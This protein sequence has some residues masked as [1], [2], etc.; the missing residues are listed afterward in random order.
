MKS[1]WVK[2]NFE[3]F[4]EIN[5]TISLNKG[6]EYPVIYMEDVIPG[7]RYVRPSNRKILKGGGAKFQDGDIL[8]ARITPCLENGKIAQVIG[9]GENHGFGSTEFFVFREREKISINSFIYYLCLTDLLRKTAERSMTGASGRQRANIDALKD[10]E[11]RVPKLSFQNKISSILGNFDKLIKNNLDRILICD[12]ISAM[13]FEEWFVRF[14]FPGIAKKNNPKYSMNNL[15]KG[16]GKKRLSQICIITMGQS[17]KSLYYNLDGI[18][19]PFHQGV[20]DFEFRFPK[21]KRYCSIEKRVAASGDVLFSVRAPVGRLN[22]SKNK[23]IIGRGL[24]AIRSRKNFQNFIFYQLKH[25]FYEEDIIGAGTIYKAVTKDDVHNIEILYPK[26]EII[27]EFEK[28]IKPFS[29]L[30]LNLT[31]KNECLRQLR[32]L[33]LP[34]LVFGEIHISD[35]INN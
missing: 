27:E 29:D 22:I 23:I 34:K 28:I 30:I 12:K 14:K 24:C 8:F 26:E 18:G 31:I 33:L 19:L 17:P 13:I 5:P 7:N 2:I 32:D 10:L 6:N 35:F 4:V 3:D 25:K 15:P 1:E 9:L 20:T 16:W 11:L 21:T